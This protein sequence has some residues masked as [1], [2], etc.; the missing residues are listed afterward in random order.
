MLIRKLQTN[1]LITVKI[2]KLNGIIVV[3]K[4][5]HLMSSTRESWHG[6][7]WLSSVNKEKFNIHKTR[8]VIWL[9]NQLIWQAVWGN[10]T[11]LS[12]K[13]MQSPYT[14]TLCKDI[15]W[16]FGPDQHK[17]Q[18]HQVIYVNLRMSQED[19]IVGVPCA[20]MNLNYQLKE[21]KQIKH[22]HTV[23]QL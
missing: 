6:L 11:V 15:K 13:S 8:N 20:Q 4:S 22:S 5:F 17:N 18:Q 9:E 12:S 19:R 1:H 16:M 10:V 2:Y 3:L 21:G 23:N 14:V 7:A